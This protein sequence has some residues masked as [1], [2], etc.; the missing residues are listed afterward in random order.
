MTERSPTTASKR[1]TVG[2]AILLVVATV[3]SLSQ[4]VPKVW[5]PFPI[6]L[7]IL[8]ILTGPLAFI[9]PGVEFLLWSWQLLRGQPCIPHRS[10][11]ALV[12][13]GCLSVWY[14]VGAWS[15]GIMRYGAGYV[16]AVAAANVGFLALLTGLSIWSYKR[17][18]F[19]SSLL[20][21][22]IMFLWLAWYAFPYFGE[23]I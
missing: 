20:F 15:E 9:M 11:G 3:I 23:G 13:L 22:S 4:G 8:M 17:P 6:P 5:A 21:H 2:V 10:V 19:T 18:T 7:F 1:W 16:V 12:I 14:F